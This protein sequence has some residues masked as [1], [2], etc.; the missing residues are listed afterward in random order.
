MSQLRVSANGQSDFFLNVLSFDAPIKGEMNSAQTRQL[1]QYYPI[2][3]MQNDL[4]CE[5]I[6]ASEA[7]WQQ[8]QMW[9][10]QHMVNAQQLN[11][12]GGLPGVQLNWPQRGINQWSAII[13]KQDGGGKRSNY[14]P[15]QT[16]QFQLVV[17]LVSNLSIFQS[18]GT[19]WQMLY[20]NNYIGG[21]F[22]DGLLNPPTHNFG[23]VTPGNAAIMANNQQ[24]S[25]TTT[26]SAPQVPGVSFPTTG[27]IP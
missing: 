21:T 25:G 22:M 20:S 26:G 13:P 23:A 19:A 3:S 8:W 17:N 1:A 14:T 27:G 11:Y 6:F 16:V 4:V 2:K 15:R 7:V 24:P 9:V 18:W 5:C 10:Y 12:S